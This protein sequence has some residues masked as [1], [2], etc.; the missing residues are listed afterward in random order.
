M[1][2]HYIIILLNNF[3]YKYFKIIIYGVVTPA[4]ILY[5]INYIFKYTIKIMINDLVEKKMIEIIKDT[6]VESI[7]KYILTIDDHILK[8]KNTLNFKK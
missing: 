7:D 4:V 2:Y 3:M 1:K 5:G 8:I 6:I